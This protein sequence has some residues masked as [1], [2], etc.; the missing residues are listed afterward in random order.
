MRKELRIQFGRAWLTA[1]EVARLEVGS[2]IPLDGP[3]DTPVSIWSG[4]RRIARGAAAVMDGEFCV[5]VLSLSSPG[6]G[7][8]EETMQIDGARAE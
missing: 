8:G 3:A 1:A 5:R 6:E 7:V 2:E 4:G